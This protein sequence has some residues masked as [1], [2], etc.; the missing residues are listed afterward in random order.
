MIDRDHKLPVTTQCQILRLV[1]SSAYYQREPVSPEDLALMRRIDE[2]HLDYPFAGS[3]MLPGSARSGT[4][5]AP[6]CAHAHASHGH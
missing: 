4:R 2:L 6:A 5:G 1:R 3:R